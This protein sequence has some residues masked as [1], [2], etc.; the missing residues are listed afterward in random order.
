M[1]FVITIILCFAIKNTKAQITYNVFTY[2]EPKGYKK[3]VS[4][5]LVKYTKSNNSNY[6]QIYFYAAQPSKGSLQLDFDNEWKSL[7]AKS[8]SITT[9]P[10]KE[11]S[12]A[13][14]GWKVMQGSSTYTA[15][16]NN[17]A[18]LHYVFS[19]NNKATSLVIITNNASYQDDIV[20]LMSSLK[21]QQTIKNNNTQNST[22]VNSNPSSLI[23][24][25]YLS[26][27]NAK[28]ILLFGP[29]GRYDQGSLVDRRIVSNLYE[30]TTIKGRG[31]YT[32]TGTTLTLTPTSGSKEV[33][34]IRFSSDTDSEG[35]PQRILH[36]KRPVAGGQMY[37]SDYYFVPQKNTGVS[38]TVTPNSINSSSSFNL[39]NGNGITGVW[40]SFANLYAGLSNL[41]WN[42]RVF[43]NNGKSL[44]NIPNGGF[45]N[46]ASGVYFDNTKNTENAFSLGNYSFANAK[47]SNVK[48]G[49]NVDD[50]LIL[51]K[52]NQLKIDGTVYMKCASVN[53]QKLN[54]SFTTFAN[55]ND[56]QL[57]TLPYGEKPKITFYNDGK[58]KDEGLFNTY[59]F[60]GAINPAAAK[61]GDGTYELK[62]YSIILKYNDGRIRQEAFTI[63]FSNTTNN[64]TIIFI[65]KSQINKIK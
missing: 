30:T 18:V 21:L 23:G 63:P 51:D 58:F 31:T 59:L 34:Q 32:I 17:A 10:K 44:S 19:G 45:A 42:W 25:W 43:F 2:T 47:G 39:L 53:G 29:N 50:K 54:G 24:E 13:I 7:T 57:Q 35:K 27:G 1:K 64:A 20:Q 14:N 33:Y 52:P 41:S 40:V 9:Q 15:N 62:D 37:E 61:A 38:N 46:L 16:G 6:C 56:P 5:S 12:D 22:S 11:E 4:N 60:D 3:E 48:A 36:L 55:P 49:A 8:L 28:T 65:S 26:D